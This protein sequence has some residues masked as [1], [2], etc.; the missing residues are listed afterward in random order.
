[1][2]GDQQRK[3]QI[4]SQDT[5]QDVEFADIRKTQTFRLFEP[6]GEPVVGDDGKTEWVALDY[7]FKNEQGIL[8]VTVA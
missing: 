4:L 7:P 3:V 5:W 1:M 6:T 2:Q 8:Q